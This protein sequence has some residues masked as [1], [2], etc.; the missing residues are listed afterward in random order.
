MLDESPLQEQWLYL[1]QERALIAQSWLH[2]TLIS[3]GRNYLKAQHKQV[4]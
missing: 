1:P 2:W 4:S 3:M